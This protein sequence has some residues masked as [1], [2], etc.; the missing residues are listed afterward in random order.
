LCSAVILTVSVASTPVSAVIAT[1]YVV[2]TTV[3]VFITT[4][5][6]NTFVDVAKL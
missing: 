3:S 4:V 5:V 6:V 1:A 2:I